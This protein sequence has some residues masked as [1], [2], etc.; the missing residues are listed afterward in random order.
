MR[1]IVAPLLLALLASACTARQSETPPLSAEPSAPQSTTV[2]RPAPEPTPVPTPYV[3]P[4]PQVPEVQVTAAAAPFPMSPTLAL[5]AVPTND[6]H[7][8]RIRIG[9][10]RYLE[11]LNA[12]RDAGAKDPSQLGLGISGRFKDVVLAGMKASGTNGVKRK[13]AI[14]SFRVDR[15][16]VKPWGTRA[17]AEV[18]AT[19]L[20]K[21][22]DGSAPDQVETG[23]LR[24]VGDSP[25][26]IDGWDVTKGRW[27]NGFQTMSAEGV[28]TDIAPAISSLLRAESW[29]PGSALETSFGASGDTP[30][31]AARHR[32]LGALDRANSSSR[33]FADVVATV[34]R[35]ETFR[36][37]RDGVA[38]VRIQGVVLTTDPA[39]KTLR[40]PFDRQA[41]VLFGNWVPE[42]VDE[43]IVAGRW[44][45]GGE[46]SLGVRD[47]NFA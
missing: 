33:T 15:L 38:T 9:L 5:R 44:L 26:V 35:Y 32:Y 13:F 18:T 39:G 6:E 27:F 1:L 4:V 43:Q 2:T 21:A 16:L 47:H 29:I 37:I 8:G 40:E 30:Y 14:G 11:G 25:M 42:V 22:V 36:E 7:D 46:L 3:A 31:F 12:Y 19:I 20:D 34:V 28:R 23:R 17:V 10:E 24:L 45:S 41:V